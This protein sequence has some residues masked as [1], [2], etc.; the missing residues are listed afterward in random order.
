[1]S[2]G[3]EAERQGGERGSTPNRPSLGCRRRTGHTNSDPGS[4]DRR[5]VRGTPLRRWRA[6]VKVLQRRRFELVLA[7]IRM[8]GMSGM[9]LL[10]RVREMAPYTEVII[11]TAFAS[12]ETVQ[13]CVAGSS[14]RLPVQALCPRRVARAGR[15][16]HAQAIAARPDALRGSTNRPAGAPGLA[17]GQGSQALAPGIQDAGLSL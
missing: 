12:K 2:N 17:S 1:M 4:T 16:G 9:E 13:R 14:V 10:A 11:M 6:G 8:P 5:G 7:D 3:Q 15:R